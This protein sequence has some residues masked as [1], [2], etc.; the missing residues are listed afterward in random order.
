[1]KRL[2]RAI[3][4]I[5][6]SISFIAPSIS[7]AESNAECAIWLCLPFGF[8]Y[9]GCEIAR[10]AMYKRMIEFKS[11][12]PSWSSCVVG[13]P[14]GRNLEMKFQQYA[15]VD[16]PFLG[17]VS[18]EGATCTLSRDGQE[19]IQ[20][21]SPYCRDTVNSVDIVEN[22]VPIGDT[23]YIMDETYE[24]VEYDFEAIPSLNGRPLTRGQDPRFC[25]VAVPPDWCRDR[26]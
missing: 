26:R 10:T 23:Y 4:L 11:P 9:P 7:R 20:P 17:T 6:L 15:I 8:M 24:R 3:F 21:I 25:E 19:E 22:G 14:D 5:V 12:V 2:N 13:D 18:V 1:M 16:D